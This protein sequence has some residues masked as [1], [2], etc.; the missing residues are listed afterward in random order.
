MSLKQLALVAFFTSVFAFV[1]CGGGA[2]VL[3]I[4]N[5]P[6]AP[7]SG[8]KNVKDIKRTIVLAG[9]RLGWQMHPVRPGLVRATRFS[10]GFMAKVDISYTSQSYS[11][12]YKD[13]SNLKYD[14]QKIHGRYNQWI[15]QLHK[16]I[17]AGLAKI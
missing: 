4:N 11:I 12:T 6:V 17:R 2:P 1:G 5:H 10:Q 3:N 9:S 8:S 15:K 7:K 14:G 13:S 16:H